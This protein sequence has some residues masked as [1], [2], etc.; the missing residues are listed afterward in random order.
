MN[1]INRWTTTLLLPAA[2]LAGCTEEASS[3][4]QGTSPAPGSTPAEV[5][6]KPG[7]GTPATPVGPP[8]VE[9]VDA[10]PGTAPSASVRGL[11]LPATTPAAPAVAPATAP[12]TAPALSA[13]GAA[14]RVAPLPAADAAAQVQASIDK[15]LA[16]LKSKQNPDGG[17]QGENEPPAL[18]A[19]VLKAFVQD[20]KTNSKT[21]F[22][23]KGYDKLLGYQLEDGGIYKDLLANY[24]TAIA[25]SALSAAND[26]AFKDRIDRAVAYLKG[27]QWT[28]RT[29]GTGPKG[30]KVNDPKNPWYG[31][32]GYGR[33]GRPDGSN[34][35]ITTDALKD[36][37]LK[38]EDP[39]FQ[40][41]LKFTERQQNRS[42]SND[43]PWAGDDGG[44]VY[45]PANNG[46]SMAGAYASPDGRRMLRSY[47]SM[48]YAMLKSYMYAGLKKEDA[49]VTAAWNWITRN[50]TLEE[51]PGMRLGK[52]DAA[53]DG[54]FY[55]YHTL[56]R[57][58][59]AYDEPVVTDAK[60]QT[61]DWRL[62][63]AAK[64]A[65]IQQADG[66]W[67]GDKRW[68]EDKPVLTTALA[69]LAMQEVK[70]DLEEHPP[71]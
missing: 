45:T 1:T 65:S 38:A 11:P 51:N 36:A 35:Q 4:K 57:A 24:N 46:E 10:A 2:L 33:H 48:T 39:A 7:D 68:M 15:A 6:T 66:H 21:D 54:L 31:G 49:R 26:P 3:S 41:A 55:Y 19:V 18:T 12:S 13:A 69:V 64:L 42:E 59:N 44:A 58:L 27:L 62:E 32:T 30:E 50:W 20:G 5:K 43:Q 53:D 34:L 9:R 28:E 63:L 56:A 70:R 40:A 71:K 47:G 17:W 25:V 61:H 23:K 67:V 52:P 37:G 22:V 16:F 29:P 8:T 14:P 60:G